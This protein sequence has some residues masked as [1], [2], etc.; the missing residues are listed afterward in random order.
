MK[1]TME[2]IVGMEITLIGGMV[3]FLHLDGTYWNG[4]HIASLL[5]VAAG[6]LI[7]ADGYFTAR[8]NR[9]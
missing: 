6:L 4:I 5:L 2:Q 3:T 8:R 9:K 1:S 7:T